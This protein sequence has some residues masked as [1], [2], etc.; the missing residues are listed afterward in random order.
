[1][2]KVAYQN[3]QGGVVVLHPAPWA[4][5]VRLAGEPG[6]PVMPFDVLARAY[7][8]TT[9]EQ[10]PNGL[11][12]EWAETE[13]EFV[14]RIAAKDAAGRDYVLVDELPEDRSKRDRWRLVNGRVEVVE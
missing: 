13:D 7:Q 1:M 10:L 11:K 3:P 12:A 2:K 6:R 9:I 5:L 14:E 8:V 4:R